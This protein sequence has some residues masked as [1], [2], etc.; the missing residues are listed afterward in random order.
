MAA[1]LVSI[2][3]DDI[4]FH[5]PD[6]QKPEA[7]KKFWSGA[8]L[9]IAKNFEKLIG[10]YGSNGHTTWADVALFLAVMLF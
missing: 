7:F 9:T 8:A 4:I 10:W 3:Y 5:N 2:Y 6:E 1:E